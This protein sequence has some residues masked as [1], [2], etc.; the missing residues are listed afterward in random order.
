LD[1]STFERAIAG[2]DAVISALGVT[3][4][5]PTTVY[6]E[7]IANIL[8]AMRASGVRR[9]ICISAGG[10]DPGPLWQRWIAKPLLWLAFKNGYS[11]MARM[12]VEVRESGLDWTIIRPPRLTDDAQTGR[13]QIAIN[14]HLSRGW[15]INR[16]DLA[17]YIVKHRMIARSL[18]L[19]ERPLASR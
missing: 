13:Y 14:Q 3:S 1:P 5:A 7:G 17:D 12:E 16:A 2:K 19:V 15:K 10:L 11:D 18:L 6:S 4:R 9:L 8:R